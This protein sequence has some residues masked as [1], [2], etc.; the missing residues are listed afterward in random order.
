MDGGSGAGKGGTGKKESITVEPEVNDTMGF[1]HQDSEVSRP[2]GSTESVRTVRDTKGEVVNDP[3][4]IRKYN[5][6]LNEGYANKPFRPLSS[7]QSERDPR[8]AQWVNQQNAEFNLRPLAAEQENNIRRDIGGRNFD[9]VRKAGVYDKWS[10]E[11]GALL[12]GGNLTAQNLNAA[13]Q[14][15]AEGLLG[16]PEQQAQLKQQQQEMI[17]RELLAASKANIPEREI[18][19]KG[20]GYDYSAGLNA[21][22]LGQL[23]R[24][25]QLFESN[26]NNTLQKNQLQGINMGVALGNEPLLRTTALNQLRGN[27]LE[28]AYANPALLQQPYVAPLGAD[29]ASLQKNPLYKS[30]YSLGMEQIDEMSGKKDKMDDVFSSIFGAPAKSQ[31]MLSYTGQIAPRPPNENTPVKQP[32]PYQ[33][34]GAGGQPYDVNLSA[35]MELMRTARQPQMDTNNYAY[36]LGMQAQEGRA[37]MEAQQQQQQMDEVKRVTEWARRHGTTTNNPFGMMSPWSR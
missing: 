30:P 14:A 37:L 27:A 33:L 16:G 7:W 22:R 34:G 6:S 36:R 10:P 13:R 1:T 2:D 20:L 12:T 8:T 11:Q 9:V 17:I 24:E 28:S 25:Q 4:L 35:T 18:N 26:A 3:E 19:A 21:Q 15:N 29:G 5:Q 23:P 31:Q 32:N